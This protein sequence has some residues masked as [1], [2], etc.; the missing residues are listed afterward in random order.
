M[1]MSAAFMIA[2]HLNA[3]YGRIVTERDVAL[4]LITGEL[5]GASKAANE[6]LT[7]IFVE[8]E[9]RLILRCAKEEGASLELLW[10]LYQEILTLGNVQ[11][12]TWEQAHEH[13]RK[14]KV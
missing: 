6:I 12:P 10:R 3:P 7:G 2:T 14:H 8:L 11:S 5:S 13:L 4:S 1:N 9:P